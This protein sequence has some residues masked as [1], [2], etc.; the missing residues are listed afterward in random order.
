M[1]PSF[2]GDYRWTVEGRSD[3]SKNRICP[4][5]FAASKEQSLAGAED[6]P[7]VSNLSRA[8]ISIT[9][10]I[11][12]LPITFRTRRSIQVACFSIY[13]EVPTFCTV[14]YLAVPDPHIKCSLDKN[15]Q[16]KYTSAFSS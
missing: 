10:S 5:N 14:G 6:D 13:F 2:S 15:G 16:S 12:S 1:S 4:L 11:P 9:V 3:G 8:A 7:S